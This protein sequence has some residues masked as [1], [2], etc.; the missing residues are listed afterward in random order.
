MTGGSGPG[1]SP[2]PDPEVVLDRVDDGFFAVDDD[3]QVTYA[4]ERG[5]EIL[6][7][8]MTDDAPDADVEGRHLW[9]SVPDAVDTVFHERSH[10][11]MERQESVTFE[12]RFDPIETWFDV[13][14][15]PSES[16]LSVYFR[17][18][19]EE[20]EL[21]RQRDRNLRALQRLYA[22]SS[23]TERAFAERLDSMLELGRDYLGV[24]N[25]FLTRIESG[26]QHIEAA[27][28]TD[29]R[30]EAG[31][32]CPLEEAYCKRTIERDRLLTVVDPTGQDCVDAA[33][34]E[35]FG[36]ETY[37][38][39]RV[40]VDGDLYGTLCF[41]DTRSRGRSFSDD[42]ETF[43]E[44]L[45]RWVSYELERER[46]ADRLRRERD[47]LDQ[48]ASVVSHD[49]R[50]PLTAASA[51]VELLA[52]STESEHL[53]PLSRALDRMEELV[54]NLLTL[55]RNGRVVDDPSPVDVATV[56]E[57]AWGHAGRDGATISLAFDDRQVL[58]DES[59]L[60]QLFENLFR[61]A[62]EHSSTSPGA[63]E[64]SGV[65]VTVGTL[66][67]GSGFF[68]ADDG[69]G[70]PEA[71]REQVFET[72]YSTNDEGTGF[73]LSI[74]ASIVEAHGWELRAT[75]SEA[76]GA[77]FEVTGVDSPT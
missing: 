28:A 18:I 52:E 46:A 53:P 21:R 2:D 6:R 22:V 14:V 30:L 49:L 65:S 35:R 4:N 8:A 57:R 48:F 16:G 33:A 75:E 11:A 12:A 5:R 74:V 24:A 77:R 7:A 15:Y 67:D 27:A 70:I 62:V 38:G 34:Y 50:N 36:L 19:T 23:D 64:S 47:R 59:G 43:V 58:A 60:E 44:L 72:G 61:N 54:D 69:P 17:D 55:A 63:T 42:E 51:R 73:G 68:V 71:E 39:G 26:T 25:G 37:I 76:G 13:G 66:P 32:S 10:E 40:T 56:A 29:A 45:T 3:W 9:R 20:T 31:Q 1:D 41:A